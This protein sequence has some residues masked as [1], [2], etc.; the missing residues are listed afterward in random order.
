MKFFRQKRVLCVSAATV[1][2]ISL[3][4]ACCVPLKNDI[5][6]MMVMLSVFAIIACI[7]TVL[8]NY[9]LAQLGLMFRVED[10][11][12]AEPHEWAVFSGRIGG[13]IAFIISIITL[14]LGVMI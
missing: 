2:L 9:E 12:N 13:W 5:F 3:V 4:L 7:L 8:L 11:E 14:I 10:Y 6:A 1:W